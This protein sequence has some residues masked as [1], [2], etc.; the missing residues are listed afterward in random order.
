[1]SEDPKPDYCRILQELGGIDAYIC[2]D[3]GVDDGLTEEQRLGLL[4]D[5]GLSK[6]AISE[7][8]ER[9]IAGCDSCA[10]AYEAIND[11][12]WTLDSINER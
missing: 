1:M 6:A 5:F 8:I 7:G 2:W 10:S 9:H 11:M 4:R 3:R 12:R